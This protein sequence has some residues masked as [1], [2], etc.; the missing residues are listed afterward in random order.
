MQRN[1]EYMASDGSSHNAELLISIVYK[2]NLTD[3]L[4]SLLRRL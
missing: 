3:L 4:R 1:A 2:Q